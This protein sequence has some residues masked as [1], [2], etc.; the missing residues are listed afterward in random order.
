MKIIQK[1]VL[2]TSILGASSAQGSLK[3]VAERENTINQLADAYYR[4]ERVR[5]EYVL[6][7]RG[8][9]RSAQDFTAGSKQ[10][11]E[12]WKAGSVA[13]RQSKGGLVE[14]STEVSNFVRQQNAEYLRLK[15]QGDMIESNIRSTLLVLRQSNGLKGNE[16]VDHLVTRLNNLQAELTSVSNALKLEVTSE[17]WEMEKILKAFNYDF[18]VVRL[19][20]RAIAQG[21]DTGSPVYVSTADFIKAEVIGGPQIREVEQQAS[22]LVETMLRFEVFALKRQLPSFYANCDKA[23][24][25]FAKLGLSDTQVN[26]L[27]AEVEKAR[28]E[29]QNRFDQTIKIYTD[30]E[31]VETMNRTKVRAHRRQCNGSNPKARCDVYQRLAGIDRNTLQKYNAESLATVEESWKIFEES[32]K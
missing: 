17:L 15:A 32:I 3:E 19:K 10:W 21:I 25:S 29:V 30:L 28:A 27:R 7:D 2:A 11:L 14:L 18:F 4:Y 9:V 12:A 8:I 1:M 20:E 22:N 13:I 24:D 23:K 26:R 6:G 5:D 16:N 31:L